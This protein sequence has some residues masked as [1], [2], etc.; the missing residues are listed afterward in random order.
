MKK[1]IFVLAI[2]VLTAIASQAQEKSQTKSKGKTQYSFLWGLFKSKDYRGKNFD[3]SF[4]TSR[5]DKNSKPAIDTTKY[6]QRSI[7]WGAIQWTENKEETK[8]NTTNNE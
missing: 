8:L 7:L 5:E 3:S 1:N 6:I 2:L 4:E